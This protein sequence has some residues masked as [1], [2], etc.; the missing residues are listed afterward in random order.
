MSALLSLLYTVLIC[1]IFAVSGWSLYNLP[2]LISG[3]GILRVRKP[4]SEENSPD[5]ENLPMFSIV[6]PMKGEEKVAARLLDALSKLNYPSDKKEVIIVEDGSTDRT[7]DVCFEFKERH[8]ADIKILHKPFSDGKPSALNYGIKHARGEIIAI[9]DADSIP[10]PDSL[11][12]ACKYFGEPKVAAVQGRTLT[13]NSEENMLTKFISYEEAVWFDAYLQ[14]KDVLNLFVNLKGSCQFIKRDV[15][16]IVDGFDAKFLAEDMELSAKL[17]EHGYQIRYA[18]DVRSWQESPSNLKQLF[19][20][21]TK[22]YRGWM[23]VAFKYGRLMAKPSKITIDAE[24]T[25]LGPFILIVSLATYL[26]AFL[27]LFVPVPLGFF[28]NLVIQFSGTVTTLLMFLIG[29]ALVC[30]SRPRK[31]KNLLWLPFIYFYWSLQTFLALYAAA[32]ILLRRRRKWLK[33]DKKGI[34]TSPEI[35]LESKHA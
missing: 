31:S 25:L 17:I 2:I 15:L 20:Q 34:I 8:G 1:L 29:A 4:K 18:P 32:L 24:A 5:N 7:I 3:V 13:V 28:W 30:I 22:W 26:A 21:R 33:T 6:V 27:A 16:E 11:L 10:E 35:V 12:E 23:E 9:F 19:R 14:G